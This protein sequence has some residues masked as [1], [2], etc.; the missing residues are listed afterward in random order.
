MVFPATAAAIALFGVRAGVQTGRNATF[1]ESIPSGTNFDKAAFRLWIPQAVDRVQAI[2]VLMP[3]SNGDGRPMAT[4]MFWQDFASRHRLALVGCQITDRIHDQG[5]IEEYVDVRQGSGQALVDVVAK[6]AVAARHPELASAPFLL[7]GM[8]AGGEFNYEF[9]N[10]KPERVA[11]FV[12][13][14]GGIYY[15]ALVSR[16]AREVPGIL[17]TG[18]KDLESRVDTVTGLFALNRRAGAVW[19]LASEPNAAHI[20]GQSRDLGALLFE[21]ML[22][23]RV[24]GPGEPL[25]SIAGEPGFI[26]DLKTGAFQA[27]TD[28][29]TP[30]AP[31]AWLP[32][33]RLAKAWA[34]VVT[35]KPFALTSP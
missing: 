30:S 6:F 11:A 18:E 16:A 27:A 3:G 34:A 23:L 9:V 10:W 12:V 26:G 14:K 29:G 33:E 1:D 13:N 32:T 4:D 31:N 20:V 17:F 15:T 35:G 8:S 28:P 25:K 19:A 22:P 21:E 24:G 7:W 5:F 2:V